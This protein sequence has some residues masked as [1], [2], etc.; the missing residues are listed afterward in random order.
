MPTGQPKALVPKDLK[1]VRAQ[2]IGYYKDP[3]SY[4]QTLGNLGVPQTALQ[5]QGADAI[6]TYLNQPTPEQRALDTSMPAIQEFLTGQG[7]QFQRDIAVANDQGA[8]FGSSNAILRGEA[9]RNLYNLRLNAL[10]TL[11]ML[12]GSAGQA[13][14]GLAGQAYDIGSQ[15]AQQADVETQRRLAVR[16]WL[17][18]QAQQAAFNVPIQ[19]GTNWLNTLATVGGTVG[20]FLVGG[21][22]GAAVGAE[23]GSKVG[24]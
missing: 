17:A 14:R 11:G 22:A 19:P 6:G 18:N 15:Q 10:N 4:L 24:K 3:N 13:N 21:P 1:G 16:T 2:Q 8:R 9:L 12:S 5:R 23:A 20:G 7:P